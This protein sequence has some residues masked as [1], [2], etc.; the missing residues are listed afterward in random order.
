MKKKYK[1]FIYIFALLVMLMFIKF[2]LYEKDIFSVVIS[3]SMFLIFVNSYSHINIEKEVNELRNNNY[4]YSQVRLFYLTILIVFLINLIYM[5]II[6]IITLFLS[7]NYFLFN[8]NYILLIMG[9]TIFVIPTLNI[10]SQYLKANNLKKFGSILKLMFYIIWGFL[11]IILLIV[12]YKIDISTYMFAIYIYLLEIFAFIVVILCCL[13]VIKNKKIFKLKQIKKREE[14]KISLKNKLKN[15]FASNIKYSIK[16]VIYLSYYYV[17]IVFVFFILLYRY[18]YGYKEVISIM[19]DTYFYDFALI[20]ILV[21]YYIL[22]YKKVI[23]NT[24]NNIKEKGII[25]NLLI[26]IANKVI[27]VTILICILSGPILKLLFNSKNS[28]VFM[29]F[30]WILPFILLYIIG[31]KLLEVSSSKKVLYIT[32]LTG[33]LVKIVLTI[34]LINSFYRMGYNLIYGD[35]VANI[36]GMFVSYIMT[37]LYLNKKYKI[38]FS[39]SFEKILNIVYENIILSLILIISSMV[40]S[41]NV[42]SK[43][44]ALIV[45]IIY[46]VIYVI[47]NIIKNLLLKM[48]GVIK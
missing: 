21:L 41:L 45:I 48:R 8:Y 3:F 33:I 20:L 28:I 24:I 40:I 22:K 43:S 13:L 39:N 15:I 34:P 19:L 46:I 11:S 37:I 32:L 18:N 2:M 25:N 12:N 10:L 27:P 36:I 6:Y 44:Q 7:D 4:I 38:D 26:D 17:S 29:F 35:I 16:K 14:C 9:S 23:S 42:N 30:I 47:Y 5:G 1:N 31:I